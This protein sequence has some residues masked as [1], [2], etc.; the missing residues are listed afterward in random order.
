MIRALQHWARCLTVPTACRFKSTNPRFRLRTRASLDPEKD[1]DEVANRPRVR[2]E[3][4]PVHRPK[5]RGGKYP[6]TQRVPPM[7]RYTPRC[8]ISDLK[9]FKLKPYVEYPIKPGQ[10]KRMLDPEEETS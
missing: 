8:V 2:G 10:T 4:E 6:N 7:E 9:D 1:R 5:L 3:W